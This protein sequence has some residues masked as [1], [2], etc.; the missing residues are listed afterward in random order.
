[1]AAARQLAKAPR[2]ATAGWWRGTDLRPDNGFETFEVTYA[3]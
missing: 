1:M 2:E 3:S